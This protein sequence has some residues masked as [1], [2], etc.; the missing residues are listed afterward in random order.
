MVEQV[1]YFTDEIHEEQM[2]LEVMIKREKHPYRKRIL[3]RV[4]ARLRELSEEEQ[5]KFKCLT[6]GYSYMA[7]PSKCCPKCESSNL[8]EKIIQI[9][10]QEDKKW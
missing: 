7:P 3:Q 4:L 1:E 8:L 5:T 2:V 9:P 10:M 6:C